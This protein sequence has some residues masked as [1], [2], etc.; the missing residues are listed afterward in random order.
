MTSHGSPAAA[1]RRARVALSLA[2]A[3]LGIAVALYPLAIAGP[4]P[5]LPLFAGIAVIGALASATTYRPAFAVVGAL[6]S[7]VAYTVA[8]LLA[9]APL[10]LLAPAVA[11]AVVVEVELFDVAARVGR[12]AMVE[13]AVLQRRGRFVAWGALVG[14][15]AGYASLVVAGAVQ[16]RAVLL[17][18]VGSGAGL[19]AIAIA[20]VLAQRLVR[21]GA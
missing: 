13:G 11:V 14:T 4:V 3:A 19:G 1:Q 10:D 18:V 8:L 16:E 21:R 17:V 12:E 2:G 15:A 7:L 5:P 20:V 9:N 6:V